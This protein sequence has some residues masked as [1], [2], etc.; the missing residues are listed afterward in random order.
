VSSVAELVSAIDQGMDRGL[1]VV[2]RE[3]PAFPQRGAKDPFP[4]SWIWALGAGQS[5]SPPC[6]AR[7]PESSRC[8]RKFPGGSPIPDV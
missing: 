6:A 8:P 1:D 2:H 3:F 5:G 4:A 7:S